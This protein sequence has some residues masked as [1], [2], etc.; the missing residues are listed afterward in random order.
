MYRGA[1]FLPL[2]RCRR[3]DEVALAMDVFDRTEL[4][5]NTAGGVSSLPAFRASVARHL[6]SEDRVAYLEGDSLDLTAEA[7]LRAAGRIR[8]FSV[9]GSH[10][11]HHTVNDIRL[12]G[13]VAAPGAVVF[14]D[15]VTTCGTGAGRA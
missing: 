7:V 5:W 1:F 15:D 11:V 13:G 6:G 9:D 8:L 2:A 14:L 3:A 4:N 12:A 10:S